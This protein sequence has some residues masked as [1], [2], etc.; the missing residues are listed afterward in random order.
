MPMSI[1]T[2]EY[3]L[4]FLSPHSRPHL[5]IQGFKKAK[6]NFSPSPVSVLD[7]LCS[8]A[9]SSDLT[10][11]AEKREDF[12]RLH[13]ILAAKQDEIK[14]YFLSN[15][16]GNGLIGMECVRLCLS[17]IDGIDLNKQEVLTIWRKLDRKAKGKV[18]FRKFLTL[19]QKPAF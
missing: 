5:E 14:A 18:P 3:S 12:V 10:R 8:C 19:C 11:M 15:Y 13:G 4:R 6:A 2:G 1:P 16:D 9:S 17:K 7:R